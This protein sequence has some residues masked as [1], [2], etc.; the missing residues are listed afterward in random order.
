M[1]G[2]SPPAPAPAPNPSANYNGPT[3]NMAGPTMTPPPNTT[4]PDALAQLNNM[5]GQIPPPNA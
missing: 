5:F 1:G 2:S 3:I 4:G